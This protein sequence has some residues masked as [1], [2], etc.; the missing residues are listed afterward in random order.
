MDKEILARN[1]SRCAS[2][3]DKHANI[4]RIA[5]SELIRELPESDFKRILEIGCGTGSYTEL[6]RERFKYARIESVDIA[7]KMVEVARQKL[8]DGE[9]KF[10]VEDAEDM[11]LDSGYDLVTSNAAI[12]WFE[13]PEEAIRSYR[14]ALNRDGILAFSVFGPLTFRELENA[15]RKASA[16]HGLSVASRGF[17][18]KEATEK[19]LTKFLRKVS[20][21][22]V[23]IKEE[24]SSLAKLL[25]KI[26]YTGVRGSG[27]ASAERERFVWS[28]RLLKTVEDAY[29]EEYGRIVATYQVFLCKALR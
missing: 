9:V 8:K 23:L 10:S 5:A 18:S 15:L 16:G 21:R 25:E 3:Y 17:L 28:R 20:V 7:E 24:Y 12:Q 14:N 11:K 13:S 2:A 6:L 29:E 26:K 1:F 27:F 22:E 4:Q 19:M